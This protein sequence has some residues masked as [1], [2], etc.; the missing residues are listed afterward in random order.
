MN[1]N[2][3]RGRSMGRRSVVAG[4]VTVAVAGCTDE[5]DAS[6]GGGAVLT[7]ISTVNFDTDPHEF[8]LLVEWDGE[9]VHWD[10][11]ATG[12]EE[13]TPP[14]RETLTPALPTD[15]GAVR[16]HV[17]VA[18]ERTDTAITET[19]D[20]GCVAARAVYDPAA[21]TPL[22]VFQSASACP[23]ADNTET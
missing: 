5:S 15:P 21:E 10:A 9:I 8:R 7:E 4:L 1:H 11:H 3:H 2:T 6:D 23:D 19:S 20:T 16:L 12:T 18:G 22:R 17:R 13:E 14:Y